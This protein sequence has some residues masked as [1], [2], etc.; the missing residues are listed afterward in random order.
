ML[1]F[2][3]ICTGITMNSEAIKEFMVENAMLA[4]VA[5]AIMFVLSMVLTCPCGCNSCQRHFPVNYIILFVF[6][7]AMTY[8]VAFIC[9]FSAEE[10]VISAACMT[11]AAT[12][13]LTFAAFRMTEQQ[14]GYV[15]GLA[16]GMSMCAIPLIIFSLF[17]RNYIM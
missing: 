8:V 3:T 16:F 13:G 10:A 4:Y 11:L 2:T 7:S 6:T 14:V 15:G 5:L 1:T 9:A 12:I 17:F